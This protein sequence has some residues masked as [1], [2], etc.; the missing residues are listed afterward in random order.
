MGGTI[1]LQK[2]INELRVEF[3]KIDCPGS[4]AFAISAFFSIQF[5]AHFA[6]RIEELLMNC[7]EITSYQIRPLKGNLKHHFQCGLN[8][9][10]LRKANRYRSSLILSVL[11]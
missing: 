6:H 3:R 4:R 2:K 9:G 5:P 10:W 8:L 1:N 11:A 7:R